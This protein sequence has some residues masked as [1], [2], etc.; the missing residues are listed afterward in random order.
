MAYHSRHEQNDNDSRQQPDR[1][2]NDVARQGQVNSAD[3][4]NRGYRL[5]TWLWFVN[6]LWHLCFSHKR[7]WRS[8]QYSCRSSNP[9][10]TT[11]GL[12]CLGR[13]ANV[14]PRLHVR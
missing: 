5:S 1:A 11:L 14:L 3:G 10:E 4:E 12:L 2:D 6:V 9:N 13:S 8:D 7:N